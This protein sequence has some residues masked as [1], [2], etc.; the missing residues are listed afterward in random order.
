MSGKRSDHELVISLIEAVRDAVEPGYYLGYEVVHTDVPDDERI[1][2]DRE[3]KARW[4]ERL[5]KNASK[6]GMSDDLTELPDDADT[7]AGVHV[8]FE[9]IHLETATRA[10]RTYPMDD[11]IT[12]ATNY[13]NGNAE[14]K[15]Q[16]RSAVRSQLR[17]FYT[18]C[19][20]RV[21][22]DR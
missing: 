2:A 18:L 10:V 19:S 14:Q 6:R 9:V 3:I 5:Q 15:A 21:N 4:R 12:Q 7:V 22:A 17:A 8:L 1:A 11:L 20:S 13:Q 16:I